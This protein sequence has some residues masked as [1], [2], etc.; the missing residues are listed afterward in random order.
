MATIGEFPIGSCVSV[1]SL[2][3]R[4]VIS[5]IS[6]SISQE[7]LILLLL[8]P[9]GSCGEVVSIGELPTGSC[10]SMGNMEISVLTTSVV[11]EPLGLPLSDDYPCVLA[12]S[13]VT[14]AT[15]GKIPTSSCV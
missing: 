2:G 10:V 14:V 15:I 9:A 7:A 1:G 12:G 4:I 11:P 8:V 13:C 6:L 3:V 5:I